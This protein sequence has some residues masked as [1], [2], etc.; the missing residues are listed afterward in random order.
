MIGGFIIGGSMPKKVLITARGPS[1]SAFGVAGAMANPTMDLYAGQ[2]LI[3]TNN[4]WGTA[5][6]AAEVQATGVAPTSPV[7]SAILATLNPGAYTAIVSGVGG[8][9]GVGIVEVFE[10]DTPENPLV[11]I[12]S[13]AQVQTGDNVMIGGF[14][15]YGDSPKTVLVTARGPS[16]APFGITNPLANP[17]LQ[18]Y[19]G[20]TLVASN[21]DFGTATNLAQIQATGVAPTNALE[22]A[23]LITLNPGAYTAIVSGVGGATGVG[24]VEVFAQ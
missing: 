10:Q 15:I 14:I 17:M 16:L 6:N 22:S 18:L 20:Q 24:I 19:S 2:T 5:A 1:L 7:E 3:A 23:I 13:R 8:S 9:T 21:D 12:S 11:N 4:D